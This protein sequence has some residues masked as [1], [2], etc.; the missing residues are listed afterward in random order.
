MNNKRNRGTQL[1]ATTIR[2]LMSKNNLR[3]NASL[4]QFIADFESTD[5]LPNDLVKKVMAEKKLEWSS[6]ARIASAFGVN[7][8]LLIKSCDETVGAEPDD[9]PEVVLKHEQVNK[10]ESNVTHGNNSPVI[11][12][13]SIGGSF[14]FNG[15]EKSD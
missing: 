4:A 12:G 13:L 3:N 15:S 9:D 1:S 10:P 11:K 8:K 7:T 6:I 5:S 14:I 2:D